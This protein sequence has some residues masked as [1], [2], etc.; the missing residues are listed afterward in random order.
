M[1]EDDHETFRAA[2]AGI[3]QGN[4][5]Q[6]GEC[7]DDENSECACDRIV[8]ELVAATER[9]MSEHFESSAPAA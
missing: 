7:D 6:C 1:N 8:N 3:V 2:F 4:C 5:E 9:I